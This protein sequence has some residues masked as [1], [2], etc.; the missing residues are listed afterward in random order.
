MERVSKGAGA[1]LIPP[2]VANK[3]YLQENMSVGEKLV[4]LQYLCDEVAQTDVFRNMVERV[5]DDMKNLQAVRRQEHMEYK[6]SYVCF[7]RVMLGR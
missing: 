3:C 2:E 6:K 1:L 4:L 5:F 7:T